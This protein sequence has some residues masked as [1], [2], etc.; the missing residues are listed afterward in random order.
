MSVLAN[1]SACRGNALPVRALV[2]QGWSISAGA[3]TPA[4]APLHS[5]L[6]PGSLAP[7]AAGGI[8]ARAGEPALLRHGSRGAKTAAEQFLPAAVPLGLRS[9]S[10]R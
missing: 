5:A 3:A 4:E 9:P 8:R 2:K 7:G 10:S 1:E 6:C